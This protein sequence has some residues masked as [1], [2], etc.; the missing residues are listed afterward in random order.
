MTAM[1]RARWR[2]PAGT[3]HRRADHGDGRHHRGVRAKPG[4]APIRRYR[5]P[6]RWLRLNGRLARLLHRHRRH[7]RP[8]R[9]LQSGAP[10]QRAAKVH[11]PPAAAGGDRQRPRRRAGRRLPRRLAT[12]GGRPRVPAGHSSTSATAST[13]PRPWPSP[14]ARASGP[15][16][17]WS[18]CSTRR[19]RAAPA[20]TTAPGCRGPC[21]APAGRPA[22]PPPP[23]C[24][25]GRGS[26]PTT[27]SGLASSG[28]R[29]S[30][31]GGRLAGLGRP[32]RRPGRAGRR[33]QLGSAPA[34]PAGLRRADHHHPPH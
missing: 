14:D 6:A 31:A 32:G 21:G 13:W 26:P 25:S 2:P 3:A 18:S 9:A 27:R 19:C 23:A 8:G 34:G 15:P 33:G 10:R 28:R 29:A 7:A 4:G 5:Q 11:L 12:R 30:L 24:P 16:S 20:S 17:G 1:T 22:A